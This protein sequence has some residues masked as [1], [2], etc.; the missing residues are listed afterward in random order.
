[1]LLNGGQVFGVAF[2]YAINALN[3]KDCHTVFSPVAVMLVITF[4]VCGVAI[5]LFKKQYR[6][7]EAEGQAVSPTPQKGTE[8]AEGD[9]ALL[10]EGATTVQ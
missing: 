3:S 4:A 8:A 2:I 9:D 10:Y 6:R 5:L 7:Q 1:M